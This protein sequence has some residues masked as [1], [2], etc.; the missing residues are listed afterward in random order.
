MYI[1]K[2]DTGVEN[3]FLIANCSQKQTYLDAHLNSI[4]LRTNPAEK[5]L[6]VS[7]S[8]T[9]CS[10]SKLPLTK[11]V[12]IGVRGVRL[13]LCTKLYVRPSATVNFPFESPEMLE[14]H[15]P[16]E[17]TVINASPSG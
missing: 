8:F 14:K 1:Y 10:G 17:K 15:G 12:W 13:F 16:S 9:N 2:N 5:N 11:L 3:Y 4:H 6:S 7:Q